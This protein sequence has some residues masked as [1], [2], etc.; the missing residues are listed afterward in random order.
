MIFIKGEETLLEGNWLSNL[1]WRDNQTGWKKNKKKNTLQILFDW[2]RQRKEYVTQT[3]WKPVSW[4]N[5]APF[6]TSSLCV[7]CSLHNLGEQSKHDLPIL[8]QQQ[9]VCSRYFRDL[10]MSP[11]CPEGWLVCPEQNQCLNAVFLQPAT[12]STVFCQTQSRQTVN[13]CRI[14]DIPCKIQPTAL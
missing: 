13:V 3:V 1:E 6:V 14:M 2:E 8:Q 10:L 5:I 7:L 11:T 4:F 12:L 9:T